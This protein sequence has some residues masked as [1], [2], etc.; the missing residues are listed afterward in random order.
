MNGRRATARG[1]SALSNAASC[2]RTLRR[3]RNSSVRVAACVC[4]SPCCCCCLNFHVLGCRLTPSACI[5]G[6]SSKN[7]STKGDMPCG[8]PSRAPSAGEARC[9]PAGGGSC[10]PARGC[11]RLIAQAAT[12]FCFLTWLDGKG[13]LG[14][15][16]LAKSRD[17]AV[18]LNTNSR[19]PCNCW[20]H[21]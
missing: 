21:P 12:L 7:S 5:C 4:V 9:T 6:Y 14:M 10:P 3:L 15:Q 17:C 11:R 19:K 13:S 1:S 2:M 20:F 16:L 8:L 18:T